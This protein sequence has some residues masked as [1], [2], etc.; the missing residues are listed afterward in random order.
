MIIYS[1]LCNED[2][3]RNPVIAGL[4]LSMLWG[5]DS[6]CLLEGHT[7]LIKDFRLWQFTAAK[8]T[9]YLWLPTAC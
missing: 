3:E 4:L 6:T 9:V 7:G 2:V 1:G 5:D 8:D